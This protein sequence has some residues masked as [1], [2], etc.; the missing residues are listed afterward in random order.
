MTKIGLH[1]FRAVLA[2]APCEFRV[3][4]VFHLFELSLVG[5]VEDVADLKLHF[6][7]FRS[8]FG[9]DRNDSLEL[10]QLLRS[11]LVRALIKSQ[12]EV[13]EVLLVPQKFLLASVHVH[14]VHQQNRRFVQQSFVVQL[15]LL[16]ERVNVLQAVAADVI[17]TELEAEDVDDE[18]QQARPLHVLQKLVTHAD[19]SVRAL[20]QTRQVRERDLSVIR[21]L[22]GSDLRHDCGERIRRDLRFRLRN[23]LQQRALASVRESN[24]SDVGDQLEIEFQRPRLSF[25]SNELISRASAAATTRHQTRLTLLVQLADDQPR[26]FVDYFETDGN[27]NF[28]V[29]SSPSKDSALAAIFTIGWKDFLINLSE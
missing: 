25:V 15:Q 20:D 12:R 19:V 27:F 4:I 1:N 11:D 10:H 2:E 13:S 23:R 29:C 8:G 24:K 9:G 22:D 21:V 16:V 3:H 14:L 18:Q 5:Q 28:H 6:V 26:I 17:L 7:D